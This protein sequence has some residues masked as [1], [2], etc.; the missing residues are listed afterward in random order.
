MLAE[1]IEAKRAELGGDY[2]VREFARRTH[3]DHSYVNRVIKGQYRPSPDVLRVWSEELSPH[4]P[5]DV[6]L[7]DMGYAP[8]DPFILEVIRKLAKAPV[9]FRRRIAEEIASYTLETR[10]PP[11]S[12]ETE[13]PREEASC[14]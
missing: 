6:V 9:N 13:K 4:F 2:S 8:A 14:G 7:S 5:L 3:V 11:I 12:P 1:A 10:E